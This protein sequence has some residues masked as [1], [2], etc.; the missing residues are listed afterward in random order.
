[1]DKVDRAHEQS[2]NIVNSIVAD[3]NPISER[4]SIL[5]A[6]DQE[7]VAQEQEDVVPDI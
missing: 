1:M 7:D 4:K 5:F 6:Q 2:K 3:T